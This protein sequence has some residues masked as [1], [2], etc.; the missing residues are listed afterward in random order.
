MGKSSTSNYFVVSLPPSKKCNSDIQNFTYMKKI[1]LA[2]LFVSASF[3][4]YSQS[5]GKQELIIH[6]PYVDKG[7]TLPDVI[8]AISSKDVHPVAFCED[9]R[10]LL[11]EYDGNQPDLKNTILTN[12]AKTGFV[13]ELKKD[14]TIKKVL[15]ESKSVI[16]EATSWY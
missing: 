12:L 16:T 1:L 13:F 15:E 3:F 9:F 7:K 6:L 4:G 5:S 11:V 2:I 14:A 10:C 8:T